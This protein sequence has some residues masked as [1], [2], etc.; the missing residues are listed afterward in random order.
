LNF[1]GFN[2]IR[3]ALVDPSILGTRI[4]NPTTSVQS[5]P[6]EA[7]RTATVNDFG[8]CILGR[9][10]FY[11]DAVNNVDLSLYKTFEL[12]F[13][14]TLSH[15]I[16]VRADFFNAFNKVQYGFPNP[17]LASVNFGRITG[18]AVGYAPRNIQISFRYIF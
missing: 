5:L 18:A 7:F 2:E 1:D 11:G 10:T 4:N 15:R 3:P 16:S 17:D 6:R 9:N 13:G 14:E 12:P 8:C